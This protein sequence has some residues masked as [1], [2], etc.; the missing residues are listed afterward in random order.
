MVFNTSGD[1][2]REDADRGRLAREGIDLLH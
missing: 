1:S 2:G